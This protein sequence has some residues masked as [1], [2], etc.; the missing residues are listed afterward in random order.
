MTNIN[1]KLPQNFDWKFYIDTYPDLQRAGISSKQKAE[2]HYLLYGSQEGRRYCSESLHAPHS[3]HNGIHIFPYEFTHLTDVNNRQNFAIKSYLNNKTKNVNILTFGTQNPNIDQ[4]KYL[5]VQDINYNNKKCNRDYYYLGDVLEHCLKTTEHND[6][7]IYT[8]SDC[9]IRDNFYS[10]ILNSNYDYIEFFRLEVQNNSIISQNKDGIDGF[11]IK[12][13]VLNKLLLDKILPIDLILGSPY[14]DA[15]LSNI[16]K[17]Y[18]DNK[19]Q[20]TSRLFHNTHIPRW[21]LKDLDYG[22]KHNL[23]ILNNLYNNQIINCR[24]AE[25]QSDNL[26]IRIIDNETKIPNIK[27]LICDE[28]FSNSKIKSFDYNYLFIE[29]K[30]N[31]SEVSLTDSNIGTTAGTRYH[32]TKNNL[33]NIIN[34]EKLNF[35]KYIILKENEKLDENTVFLENK[36]S[37]LGIVICFFGNDEKRIKAT[38]RSI[39]MLKTQ[40]IW[41]KSKIVFVELIED[42]SSF[43]FSKEANIIHHKIQSNSLNKNL[44]QKECLWNIGAKKIID[45]VNNFI[46]IDSDTYPQNNKTFA[47]ANKILNFNPYIVYQLG[48]CL[49]TQKENG[50][51]TRVQWLWNSFSK[52]NAKNSYCF[53]PCGGFAISK[54]VFK[55]IDGFNPFGFLYGGD[56]LF[57][58]EIDNRTHSIWDYNI[59]NMNI[60]K[61]MPRKI[62]N[63]N[64]FIKNEEYP[65]IHCY[66]GNHENR[67]Y[68]QWGLCFNN[69]NFQ[70]NHIYLDDN[71][72][73]SW[74]NE[75]IM[76]KYSKFFLHKHFILDSNNH[77]ELYL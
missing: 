4:L 35:K 73:L 28:R 68:H 24:K 61:N 48:D 47:K 15:I 11:A 16:A 22:G 8:N 25:I 49:V 13:S 56:I 72:L 31:N 53:N 37:N 69:L 12:N 44:F 50:D 9:F 41:S 77:K 21:S 45:T 42:G 59:K 74:L 52:L 3:L 18:I 60:F 2:L 6:Y 34:K 14:W 76:N 10:F 27:K 71:Q 20:D 36:T 32:T 5:K 33:Q 65:M 55:Q 70:K 64:I 66:H 63:Q 40:S 26:V 67:P 29:V 19:F 46:F 43:D 54:K 30:N 7:I 51:I 23:D 1:P 17:R 75:D 38:L 57:L 62:N 39:N 58:Y